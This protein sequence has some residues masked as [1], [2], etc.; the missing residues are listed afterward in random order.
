M[1]KLLKSIFIVLTIALSIRACQVS[2]STALAQS[3]KPRDT[4][5]QVSSSDA[6]ALAAGNNAFALDLYHQLNGVTDNLFFSPYSISIALAMTCAGAA[7]NTESQMAQAMHFDLPQAQLHPAFNQLALEM[8]RRANAEGVD[9]SQAFT[10][11]VVNATWGQ[12]GYTFLPGY[13]DILAQEYDAGI[14]LLDFAANPESA[15]NTI[16]QWVSQETQNRI[17]DILPAGSIDTLTRLVL[18][19]AIYFKA[20]WSSEFDKNLTKDGVFHLAAGSTTTVPMM[21]RT[22]FYNY[23]SRNG[24]QA[25]ELPY[26]GEQLAL[27]IILPDEGRF[28]EVSSALDSNGL[29]GIVIDL[30]SKN[31]DVTLP[32]FS[33]E[34]NLGVKSWLQQM[35]MVDAFDP[36]RADF[37]GMDGKKD[38]YISDVL[39]K[40]FV[41]VDEAGTEAA[42]ATTVIVGVTSMPAEQPIAFK[43]DRPFIFLIRDIPTNTILFLGNMM[44]PAP[45]K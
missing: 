4:K 14:R 31:V 3:D 7:G 12:A 44:N 38:L 21:K 41:A 9:P 24:Y 30:H 1:N 36:T 5:P 42:A 40:A 13:L 27:L 37:S 15:R 8:A 34:Y 39:H 23:A 20:D 22:G 26:A 10:L 29:A 35:G 19:N 2:P 11:H 28:T 6:T 33:F 45:A 25:L 32:K 17:N 16:N 43:A 18:S